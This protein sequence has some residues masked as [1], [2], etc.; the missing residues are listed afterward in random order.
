MIGIKRLVQR[1][2]YYVQTG[3]SLGGLPLSLLNFATIF[4]YNAIA[5]ISFLK[6]I[7]TNFYIFVFI[8]IFFFTI[9]FGL[10]GFVFKR[11]TKFYSSQVEVDVDANPYMR[12]KIVP[13]SVP[14]YDGFVQLLEKNGIDCEPI[15]V[16]LRKSEGSIF[17]EGK[18]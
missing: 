2:L 12:I 10:I 14:M 3:S 16:L 17:S 7:F 4:Y 13:T 18:T 5:N 6:G 1:G 8:S 11:R 15:K 9:L